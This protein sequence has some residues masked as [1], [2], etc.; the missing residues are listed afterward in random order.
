[1]KLTES[2]LK[3]LL[4]NK[5]YSVIHIDAD[6]DNYR[7]KVEKQIE[8]IKA[9]FEAEVNF[10]YIDCDQEQ[11]YAKSVGLLNTPSIAYY[12]KE[13]LVSVIIGVNQDIKQNIED[14][15]NGI[16]PNYKN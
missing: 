6:W 9:Q 1:M 3:L 14:L 10:G 2:Q 16:K 8:S 13:E 7:F 5:P 12:H 11:N 4:L 15:K